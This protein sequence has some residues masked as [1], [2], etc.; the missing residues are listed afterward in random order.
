MQLLEKKRQSSQFSFDYCCFDRLFSKLIYQ[1]FIFCGCSV[2]CTSS[3]S[4]G[5][6][7]CTDGYGI[8]EKKNEKRGKDS[9][10]RVSRFVMS[11]L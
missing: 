11:R 4:C 5:I 8:M 7:M 3:V 9:S 6:G 2:G 1:L 10:C